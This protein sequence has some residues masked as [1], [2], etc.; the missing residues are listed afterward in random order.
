M[1]AAGRR[2]AGKRCSQDEGV[3]WVGS[4]VVRLGEL[5]SGAFE[6]VWV[7]DVDPSGV[8]V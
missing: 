6:S 2:R 8:Q 5:F 3:L 7:V 4:W 1:F